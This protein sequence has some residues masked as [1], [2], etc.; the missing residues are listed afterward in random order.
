MLLRCSGVLL[1]L[2]AVAASI[3]SRGET[4]SARR[5][6]RRNQA[7]SEPAASNYDC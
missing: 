4:V 1:G 5:K 6:P 2:H 3:L 7:G